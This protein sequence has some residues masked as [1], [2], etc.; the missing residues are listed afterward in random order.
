MQAMQAMQAETSPAHYMPL[1]I[2]ILI[3]TLFSL[4]DC[5]LIYLRRNEQRI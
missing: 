4:N 2:A 3:S 5:L 1:H